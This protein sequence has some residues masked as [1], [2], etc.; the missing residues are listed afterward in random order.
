MLSGIIEMV[1]EIIETVI[2]VPDPPIPTPIP[3]PKLPQP[4]VH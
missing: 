2:L 4:P 3:I 1:V